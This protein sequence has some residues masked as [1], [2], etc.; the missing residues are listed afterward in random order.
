MLAAVVD[1]FWVL[2]CCQPGAPP[3]RH[4][5]CFGVLNWAGGVCL[6]RV[7]MGTADELA[8]DVLINTLSTFSKDQVGWPGGCLCLWLVVNNTLQ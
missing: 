5:C 2:L 6:R 1:S 3:C 4:A 7:D 8:L